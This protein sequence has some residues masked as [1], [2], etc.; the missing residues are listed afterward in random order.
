MLRKFPSP[1]AFRTSNAELSLIDNRIDKV[2][3]GKIYIYCIRKEHQND[4]YVIFLKC[5]FLL[6]ST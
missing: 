3:P 2:I 5:H 4:N 1:N 6:Q